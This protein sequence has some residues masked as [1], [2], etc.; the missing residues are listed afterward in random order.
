[1]KRRV[2]IKVVGGAAATWSLSDMLSG[3]ADVFK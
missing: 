1:M 2:F 3:S